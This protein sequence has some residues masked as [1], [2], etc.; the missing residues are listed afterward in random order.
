MSLLLAGLLLFCG[1]HLSVATLPSLARRRKEGAVKGTVALLNV[2]GMVLIILGWRGAQTQWLYELPAAVRLLALLLVGAGIYL[3]VVAGRP[4]RIKR[5]VRHPQLTGV[6]LWSLAHLLLNGDTRSVLLFG[7]L[8]TWSLLEILFINQRD[9]AWRK[10]EAPPLGT[11]VATAV[12]AVVV[13]AAL[14]WAHPWLAG[15]PV[16]L[17][18]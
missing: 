4:S 10:P 6:L 11:D 9:G 15:V 16:Q 7:T 1:S 8:A 12:V 17:P 2:V 3:A 5:R 18:T 14:V 13:L